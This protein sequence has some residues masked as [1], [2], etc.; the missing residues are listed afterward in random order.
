MISLSSYMGLRYRKTIRASNR[1][2]VNV[3]TQKASVSIGKPGLTVNLSRRGARATL[4]IPGTGL[5]YATKQAGGSRRRG[6]LLDELLTVVF[7]VFLLG[8]L[9]VLWSVVTGIFGAFSKQANHGEL[10]E[11]APPIPAESPELG[12]RSQ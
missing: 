11:G 10:S 9:R 5:S 6:T 8:L 1:V 2:R 4:G 7:I 3:G 12:K